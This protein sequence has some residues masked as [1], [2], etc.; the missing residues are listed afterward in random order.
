MPF[1]KMLFKYSD[2]LGAQQAGGPSVLANNQ[3]LCNDFISFI[4]RERQ[5]DIFEKLLKLC[6]LG[7][8]RIRLVYSSTNLKMIPSRQN[9]KF[10]HYSTLCEMDEARRER[11]RERERERNDYTT[12][13]E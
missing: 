8:R 13:R 6:S 3:T 4:V 2:D 12:D 5:A 11:E 9:L 10:K 7:P 1:V